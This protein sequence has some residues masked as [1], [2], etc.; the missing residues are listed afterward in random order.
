M[1]KDGSSDGVGEALATLGV[2]SNDRRNIKHA[3]S[4]FVVIYMSLSQWRLAGAVWVWL[5]Q[6]QYAYPRSITLTGQRQL[7]PERQDT[8]TYRPYIGAHLQLCLVMYHLAFFNLDRTQ[9]MSFRK[10]LPIT[11]TL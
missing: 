9:T 7:N 2:L 8:I 3:S 6:F 5:E 4:A 11:Y 10:D 1:N